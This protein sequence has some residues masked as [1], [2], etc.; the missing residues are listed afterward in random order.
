[1]AAEAALQTNL[2][3]KMFT[4]ERLTRWTKALRDN[5]HQQITS[6]LTNGVGTG[7]C[8]LGKLCEVEGLTLY[9]TAYVFDD[10][11]LESTCHLRGALAVDLGS[12][13]GFFEDLKMPDLVHEGVAHRHASDANDEGVPW[14]VIA[15]H[16]DKHYPCSDE[17]I[18]EM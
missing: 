7:F 12:P 18:K 2:R 16:F 3:R 13:T 8:C 9:R 14:P 10:R 4:R 5:P 6:V 17:P 11:G 1:L 15:D